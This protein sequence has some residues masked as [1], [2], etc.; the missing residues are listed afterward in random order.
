V[1]GPQ[2]SRLVLAL[3]ALNIILATVALGLAGSLSPSDESARASS[4]PSISPP[5]IAGG[6]AAP[7]HGP[8]TSQAP[9]AEPTTGPGETPGASEPAGP[10]EGPGP[11]AS[12]GPIAVASGPPAT[13]RPAGGQPTPAPSTAAPPTSGPPAS[14]PP[15]TG[16]PAPPTAVPTSGPPATAPPTAAPS[17][18]PDD[19]GPSATRVQPPCPGTVE[20]APGLSKGSGDA[21]RPCRGGEHNGDQPG[22]DDRGRGDERGRSRVNPCRGRHRRDVA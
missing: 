10:S 18:A 15:A 11:S 21:T 7:S 8:T 4:S 2:R 3:G 20:G 22:S 6:S 14:V 17:P 9:V 13:D 19:E 5:P 12:P 16:P 1:T